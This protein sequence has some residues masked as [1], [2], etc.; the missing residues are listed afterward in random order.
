VK[1]CR[2]RSPSKLSVYVCVS[3]LP[4]RDLLNNRKNEGEEQKGNDENE[5][6]EEAHLRS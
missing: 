4:P 6:L 3:S 2:E 5:E 1:Q